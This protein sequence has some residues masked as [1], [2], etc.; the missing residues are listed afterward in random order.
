MT[1]ETTHLS[2]MSHVI[3]N[4]KTDS[5]KLKKRRDKGAN[6]G[7][8]G[9]RNKTIIISS[10]ESCVTFNWYKYNRVE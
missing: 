5:V 7:R 3:W 2:L 9:K 6:K 8:K 4:F 10:S 1:D